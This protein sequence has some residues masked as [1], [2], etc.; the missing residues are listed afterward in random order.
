MIGK[1]IGDIQCYRKYC[2]QNDS[3][4]SPYRAKKSDRFHQFETLPMI[5]AMYRIR[6]IFPAWGCAKSA[7]RGRLGGAVI[8]LEAVPFEIS[9]KS[10]RI[11]S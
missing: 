7:T 10:G 4:T 5:K 3:F 6:L 2:K 1:K 9:L 8:D 11:S